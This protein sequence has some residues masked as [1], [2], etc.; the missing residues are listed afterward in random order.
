MR[1]REGHEERVPGKTRKK[2]LSGQPL[3]EAPCALC[4][5]EADGFTA[6]L[7]DH[8]RY[9]VYGQ[10][11]RVVTFACTVYVICSCVHD[12]S[13]ITEVERQARTERPRVFSSR[14]G[15]WQ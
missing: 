8:Y 14:N 2:I 5:G 10:P 9:C 11:V 12:L 7:E 3:N 1:N 6:P 13:E 15:A 4:E